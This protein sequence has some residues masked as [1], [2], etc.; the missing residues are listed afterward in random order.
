MS[1]VFNPPATENRLLNAVID[2]LKGK[3]N[4]LS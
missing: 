2:S 4:I 3:Q 1:F